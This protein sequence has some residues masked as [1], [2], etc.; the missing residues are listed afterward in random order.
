MNSSQNSPPMA[1]SD[2]LQPPSDQPKANSGESS[3]Q[4]TKGRY[5]GPERAALI[6]QIKQKNP[7]AT[8]QEIADAIGCS[9]PTVTEWLQMLELNTVPEAR[10][11][12]KSQALRAS[13]KLSEHVEHEDARVSQGAAKAI[14]AAAGVQEGSAQ[15][16]VG[17]QVIVGSS[18]QPAGPDP[19]DN[20]IDSKPLES[21][22]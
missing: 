8:H 18:S 1:D 2:P 22:S 17:V 21:E 6:V 7:A 16:S 12:M 11:L 19:F 14:I 5:I 9:R 4:H 20:V 3:L 13:L 15:V 10:K